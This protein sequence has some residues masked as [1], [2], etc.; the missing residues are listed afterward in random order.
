MNA[1]GKQIPTFGSRPSGP[2]P[3]GETALFKAPGSRARLGGPG[4]WPTDLDL[5][6]VWAC[7]R[8]NAGEPLGALLKCSGPQRLVP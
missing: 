6:A 4:A 7:A 1:A 3:I 8:R 5:N 2:E